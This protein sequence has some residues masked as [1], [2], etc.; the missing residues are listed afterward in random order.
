MIRLALPVRRPVLALSLAVFT[1]LGLSACSVDPG[2]SSPTASATTNSAS[3]SPSPSPLESTSPSS[4]EPTP[5][6]PAPVEPA[7]AATSLTPPVN[8]SF[9]IDPAS[10]VT[11]ELT[12]GTPVADTEAYG[13][14]AADQPSVVFQVPDNTVA[15]LMQTYGVFCM[16]DDSKNWVLQSV[17]MG[18]GDSLPRTVQAR[19]RAATHD[20]FQTKM[21]LHENQSIS[22]MGMTCT[23]TGPNSVQC[24]DGSTGFNLADLTDR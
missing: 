2:A 20:W 12:T 16:T 10:V 9:T 13:F 15:C 18:P 24:H 21:V 8:D 11:T 22:W 3:A 5:D 14:S 6:E 23:T 7:P 19:G 4:T 17:S 1:G